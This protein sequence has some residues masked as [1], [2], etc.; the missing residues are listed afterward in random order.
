M[1]IIIIIH[2]YNI[3]AT[4]KGV[5][6]NSVNI[7]SHNAF[8]WKCW[9]A[10]DASKLLS[11]RDKISPNWRIFPNVGWNQIT[12]VDISHIQCT[13]HVHIHEHVQQ[14]VQFVDFFFSYQTVQ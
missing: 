9:K 14:F 1:I 11:F 4:S 8:Y 7:L 3:V 2:N 6:D 12:K 13:V 5:A 10:P